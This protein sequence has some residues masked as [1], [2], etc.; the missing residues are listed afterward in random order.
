MKR[1]RTRLARDDYERMTKPTALDDSP[2]MYSIVKELNAF[3]HGTK[4]E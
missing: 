4:E 3:K 1:I 2:N